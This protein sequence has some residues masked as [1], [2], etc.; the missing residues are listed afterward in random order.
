M[1]RLGMRVTSPKALAFLAAETRTSTEP[2]GREPLPQLSEDAVAAAKIAA[3]AQRR[4]AVIEGRSAFVS[5]Q[6][7]RSPS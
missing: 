6:L 1:E 3:E 2:I 7:R 5:T 4:R